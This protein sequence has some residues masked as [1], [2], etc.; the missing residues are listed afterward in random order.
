VYTD[1][2]NNKLG[3]FSDREALTF[4]RRFRGGQSPLLSVSNKRNSSPKKIT[5]VERLRRYIEFKYGKINVK[6]KEVKG[7]D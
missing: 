2:L 4:K 5:P 6:K 1:I 7:K 3:E